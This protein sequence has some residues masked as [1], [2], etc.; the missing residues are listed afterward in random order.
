MRIKVLS[1][2]WKNI[3]LPMTDSEL[4]FR[5]KRIGIEETVPMCR[6]VEVSE[7][8]NPLC[9]FEGQ[10]VNMDEVNYFA[11][12]ME[13]LT[14][15][16]RKTLSAYVSGHGVGT[17][18]DM[19]NLTFSMK[20]LSL[21]TDFSDTEQ[22]GKRLYL[23]EFLGMSEEEEQQTDFIQFADKTLK[24]NHVEVLP[25][26]VF[27]EH[28]FEMQ[29]VY[30]G[31]TF[32]QYYYDS[33]QTVCSI[34]LQNRSGD[35]DYLYLPTDICSMNKVK[36]RLGVTGFWECKVTGI[37]NLRLPEGILPEPEKIDCVEYLTYFNEMCQAVN[38]FDE[39]Q[40]RNLSMAAEFAGAKD[41]TD[42]TFLA[43]HLGE[44]EIHPSIHNDAEYGK[45]LVTESGLFEVDELLLQHIDYAAF[46][47]D[48][49]S[50]TLTDSGYVSGGFVGAS[51]EIHEYL[52]YEGEFAD[53][54][55]IDE[56]CYEVFRLYS[57]LTGRLFVDGEDAGNLYRSDLTP[58]T[59]EI[60]KAIEEESCL[61]EEARGLMHY[62]DRS[63]EIAA[64]VLSANPT[65][66]EIGGELYGVLECR[67]GEPLTEEDIKALKEYWTGQ[68]SDGWGEGFE[69]RSIEVE[70]GE[71]YVSFWN[72][73]DFWYVE[74]E[75]ELM[76][77]QVQEMDMP[78]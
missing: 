28:G 64:K 32:P 30:N 78:C 5:M 37:D 22:V 33:D 3:E 17:M 66:Q 43:E 20:G 52:Q 61:G 26:G 40:M 47:A 44:F 12:R 9:A 68:M 38:R 1:G 58:Y 4:N 15:Y 39:A 21:I 60:M 57:P 71:I 62:F 42:I 49:R 25:Y 46:G 50:G 27:V 48:K 77:G 67:I 2:G 6:L 41:C 7:K 55:E 13:S 51:K 35:T 54:L 36:A 18:Q 76:G 69:Q 16:E 74:T 73:E 63:R 23:D 65:V 53:P 56:D 70:D 10:T 31:K 11:K 72:S 59:D 75:E 19:I 29:E 45:Y 24:G 34:E 14:E 8:D